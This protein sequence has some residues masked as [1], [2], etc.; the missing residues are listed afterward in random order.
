VIA[1][2]YSENRNYTTCMRWASEVVA[3]GWFDRVEFL[4]GPVGHTHNGV[5]AVHGVHNKDLL[6]GEAAY[7]GGL[8]HNYA[9]HW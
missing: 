7:L 5:D 9:A 3:A 2:N 8:F 4:F 6:A 1:D